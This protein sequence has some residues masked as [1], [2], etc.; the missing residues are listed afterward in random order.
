MT[1]KNENYNQSG[2]DFIPES[3]ENIIAG[4]KIFSQKASEI[5][6]PFME[7]IKDTADAA[8]KKGSEITETVTLTAQN[9]IDQ[10]KD[11]SEMASLKKVRDEVATKLG[12]M[13]YMEYSGRYKIR[14]EFTKSDEF[15]ELVAQIRELDKEIIK[16]G[17]RLEEEK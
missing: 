4:A 2:S 15:K 3:K 8:Y 5:F 16:I 1:D 9:Y 14:V 7:K 10:Y 6:N 11:R 12:D 17:K 13:C